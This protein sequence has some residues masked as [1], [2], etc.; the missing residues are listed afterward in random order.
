MVVGQTKETSEREKSAAR[1]NTKACNSCLKL[2]EC[3]RARS[4][5]NATRAR[6]FTGGSTNVNKE[7]PSCVPAPLELQPR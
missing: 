5:R 6:P 2:H 4:I 1:L 3:S 7:N